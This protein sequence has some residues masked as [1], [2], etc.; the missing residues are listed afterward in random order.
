MHVCEE[1]KS[2]Q[3]ERE[4]ITGEKGLQE[5]KDHRREMRGD[6]ERALPTC[7]IVQ[8]LCVYMVG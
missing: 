3:G 7:L 2:R 8:G 5:R 6:T 4:R 1:E